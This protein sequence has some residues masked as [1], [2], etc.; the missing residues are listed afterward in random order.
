LARWRYRFIVL[1]VLSLV[2]FWPSQGMLESGE[3]DV[4]QELFVLNRSLEV[5]QGHLVRLE[6]Q[7]QGVDQQRAQAAVKVK[8]LELE[9]L[10]LQAQFARRAR[11]YSE[12]GAGAPFAILLTAQSFPDFLGRLETLTWILQ[13]DSRLMEE[14]RR[15]KVAIASRQLELEQQRTELNL[16]RQEQQAEVE[17]LRIAIAAKESILSGL[18]EQRTAIESRLAELER[19]YETTAKPV[20]D[21]LGSSLQTVATQNG[22]F[23][24]DSIKFTLVPPGIT[25]RISSQ[26]LTDFFQRAEA[27]RGLSI[28]VKP[29][30]VDLIGD[31]DST[32]LQISGRFVIAGKQVMRYE[33]KEMKV[34]PYVVPEH[35]TRELLAKGSLDVDIASLI[36][37][38]SLQEVLAE[39]GFL[40][41]KAGLR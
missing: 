2:A 11:Y 10:K 40:Q 33:P 1:I 15:V 6:G 13:R 26:N 28:V 16:L 24:P 7:I 14:V 8:D 18:R 31:F 25:V 38:W 21:R 23:R 4:L 5:T 34:G 9:R 27:L 41:I 12:Q 30:T 32:R 22:E 36:T 20:L 29:D 19:Q 17:T 39:E 3:A 35:I 37:P